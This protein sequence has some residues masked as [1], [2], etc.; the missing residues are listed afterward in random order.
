MSSIGGAVLRGAGWFIGMRFAMRLVGLISM[1]IIARLLAPADFGL[2]SIAVAAVGLVS[3][4]TD[5]G[6]DQ[7]LIREHRSPPQALYNTV[8]TVNV[9]VHVVAALAI[10]CITPLV[11]LSYSQPLYWGV[12][13]V[14]A[15]GLLFEGAKNPAVVDLRRALSFGKD[16]VY[17]FAGNFVGVFAGVAGAVVFRDYKALVIGIVTRQFSLAGLSFLVVHRHPR[18]SLAHR[19]EVV[20]YSKWLSLRAV[21]IF[22]LSKGDRLIAGAFFTFS[23]VGFYSIAS[24]LAALLVTELLQPLGRALFPGLSRLQDE[25]GW[26]ERT[27]PRVLNVTVSLSVALGIGV[28]LVAGD[29][30]KLIYGTPYQP[31]AH[32]LAIIACQMALMGVTFPLGH[33]LMLT[34]KERAFSQFYLVQMVIGLAAFTIA[35][36]LGASLTVYASVRF[37]L[38]P[39]SWSRFVLLLPE[40]SSRC[41]REMLN[42]VWRPLV[43][44]GVMAVIV[45]MLPIQEGPFGLPA[46]LLA[47]VFTGAAAYI[48]TSVLLWLVSGRPESIE[49]EILRIAGN[50]FAKPKPS[51]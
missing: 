45:M 51:F 9:I 16:V 24:D 1:A 35:G 2:V 10:I 28:A 30:V 47:K 50:F 36:M 32:L 34:R 7:L 5:L 43:A 38:I 37:L 22:L 21:S 4:F 44:G 29:L 49:T 14:L 33:Y 17:L 48:T 40:I 42:A 18:F 3:A 15:L 13:P 20:R 23:Q 46:I 19:T 11:V 12:L 8:W 31:A 26:I 39:F 41:G 27:L 25:E 6:S